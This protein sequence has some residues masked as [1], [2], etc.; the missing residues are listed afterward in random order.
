MRR[1]FKYL[2]RLAVLVGVGFVAYAMLVDLP[3]PT[4]EKEVSLALPAEGG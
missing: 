4:S 2:F 1:L 3:P